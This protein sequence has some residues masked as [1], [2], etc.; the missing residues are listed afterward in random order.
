MNWGFTVQAGLLLVAALLAYFQ[1]RNY[2]EIER[3]RNTQSLVQ[4][5]YADCAALFDSFKI[6]EPRDYERRRSE[7]TS[8]VAAG[9]ATVA[10]RARR[11]FAFMANAQ[12]LM[13]RRLIDEESFLFSLASRS[14][15]VCYVLQPAIAQLP[16]ARRRYDF[17]W[18]S[19]RA[20]RYMVDHV[21]EDELDLPGFGS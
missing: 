9:D 14:F 10:E 17:T 1:L 8:R 2:N 12:Y 4:T 18:L 20:Y 16:N 6:A 7:I 21:L 5:W 19:R 15:A 13:Q 11:L 3:F